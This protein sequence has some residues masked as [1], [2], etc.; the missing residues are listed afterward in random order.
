[1]IKWD[2]GIRS[3]VREVGSEKADTLLLL[4]LME[5]FGNPLNSFSRF[6]IGSGP[7]QSWTKYNQKK[8]KLIN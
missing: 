1:M 3:R 8:E 5:R 4:P 7:R 6:W 2:T